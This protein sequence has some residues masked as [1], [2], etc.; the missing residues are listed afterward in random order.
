MTCEGGKKMR[1]MGSGRHVE[2][3]SSR[4]ALYTQNMLASHLGR[5]GVQLFAALDRRV[6][7]SAAGSWLNRVI[8]GPA[9]YYLVGCADWVGN[10]AG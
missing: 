8:D 2:I 6:N 4:H 10:L 3:C 5:E 7:V 1:K 9:H